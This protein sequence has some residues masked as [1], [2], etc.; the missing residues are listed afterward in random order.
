MVA[1][2]RRRTRREYATNDERVRAM[3]AAVPV[4]DEDPTVFWGPDFWEV[5]RQIEAEQATGPRKVYENLED[6]FADLEDS[7]GRADI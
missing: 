1:R 7:P 2:R 4:V 5:K 6:L 3:L